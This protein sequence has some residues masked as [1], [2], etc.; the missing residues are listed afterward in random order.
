MAPTIGADGTSPKTCI[1]TV[2]MAMAKA[3]RL[4]LTLLR[5]TKFTG[6]C[7]H[8]HPQGLADGM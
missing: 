3:C 2:D 7:H 5:E 6:P 1:Q 8:V 4:G